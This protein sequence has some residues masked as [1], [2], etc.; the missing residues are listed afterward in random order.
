[1]SVL[2]VVGYGPGNSHAVARRFGAEGYTVALVGRSEKRLSDG[3][4]RLAADRVVAHAFTG[5]AS[6]P[7]SIRAT[8]GRVRDALGP[9]TAV[10]FAAYRNVIV[11]DVLDTDPEV[12][13]QVFRIGV[14]GLLATVQA[15][16]DDL[17]AA[18]DACVLVVN[19]ALGIQN[20]AVDG[21]AVS[22]G[23]DGVALECAAKSKLVGLLA[24]RLRPDGVYVGE[25][26]IDGSVKGSPHAGPTAI[27]PADVAARLWAMAGSRDDV[28][29]HIAEQR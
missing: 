3:V 12:V 2:L 15:A 14:T 24:E 25:I 10:A 22:F 26:I 11:S 28:H 9:I 4:A 7:V 27:D 5:D 17:R 23:G 18:D 29:T 6:D 20:Q 21:F 13:N 1:M 8:V 16:L 19:G